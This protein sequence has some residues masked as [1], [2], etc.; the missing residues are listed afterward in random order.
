[1][2][3]DG[4]GSFQVSVDPTLAQVFGTLSDAGHWVTAWDDQWRYVGI[5]DRAVDVRCYWWSGCMGEFMFGPANVEVQTRWEGTAE[6][7]R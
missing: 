2:T 7:G 6:L 3:D 4:A 1:M 5:S